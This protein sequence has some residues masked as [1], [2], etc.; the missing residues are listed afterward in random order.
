MSRVRRRQIVLFA[1]PRS[2][3]FFCAQDAP[4]TANGEAE[5]LEPFYESIKYI[6]RAKFHPAQVNAG[7]PYAFV[8][9]GDV[10]VPGF[11]IKHLELR[12][13]DYLRGSCRAVT[14]ARLPFRAVVIDGHERAEDV[15]KEMDEEDAIDVE[16]DADHRL[17]TGILRDDD[18]EDDESGGSDDSDDMAILVAKHLHEYAE[19]HGGSLRMAAPP[20]QAGTLAHYYRWV[21]E[22]HYTEIIKGWEAPNCKAGVVRVHRRLQPSTRAAWRVCRLRCPI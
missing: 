16:D 9:V 12:L 2:P 5:E 7:H 20:S 4:P 6:S 1:R 8:I 15:D 22:P 17:P 21:A 11:M 14:G 3:A 13:G 19:R 10:Y 18:D